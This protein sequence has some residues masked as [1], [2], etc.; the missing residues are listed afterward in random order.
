M[1]DD[2]QARLTALAGVSDPADRACF[3]AVAGSDDAIGRDEVAERLGVPRATVAFRLDRLV[4]LGLLS[5]EFRRRS[6]RTGPGAGRPAKLYRLAVPEVTASVPERHYDL[7]A[8]LLATA[9]EQVTSGVPMRDALERTAF[10]RGIAIGA[11]AGSL[12][13]ALEDGGYVPVPDAGDLR[14]TNCPFHRLAVSHTATICAVN[15]ALLEGVLQ[16]VGDD[17][18]RAAFEPDPPGCCV[19]IRAAD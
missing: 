12:D 10:D 5:T 18:A 15:H 13:A 16:G 8:D 9:V 2:Q 14:L 1:L 3:D 19:R 11:E 7:A 17:P 6:G 4:A